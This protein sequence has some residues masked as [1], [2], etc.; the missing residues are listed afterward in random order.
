MRVTQSEMYRTFSS[1][2]RNINEDLADANSQF[3]SGKKIND[4]ADSPGGSADLV[5]ITD[6]ALKVEM[7]HS[8][9][10]TNN[11][12]LKSAESALNEANNLLS[13]I[14]TLGMQITAET[15]NPEARAA[16]ID[17][18]RVCREQM[19]S[20]ANSQIDGRYLFAGTRMTTIPF[21]LDG[22][23]V[24]YN[25]NDDVNTVSVN[26]GV[27]V[28]QGVS[29]SA[30]FGS[31]F[32]TIDELLANLNAGDMERSKASLTQ[33]SGALIDLSQ[34]RGL[35]GANLNQLQNM[36]GV[37][38]MKKAALTERKSNIEDAN[39]VEVTLRLSQLKSALDG[40]LSVGGNM[41]KQS[42]LFDIL[43]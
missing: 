26:D 19:I 24:I 22:D 17:Q 32:S 20:I 29:G 1:D 18:L 27:E 37:L 13:S 25:G 11:Y 15:L 35:I 6:Q 4:L 28:P 42:N 7:Y 39:S 14:H 34:S 31:I 2:I 16:L 33:F 21:E 8:N 23:T 5:R 3:S 30:A 36:S 41:L 38:D 12:Y 9:I 40:A 10:E 43:G